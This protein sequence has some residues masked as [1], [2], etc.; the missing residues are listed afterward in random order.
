MLERGVQSMSECTASDSSEHEPAHD[1]AEYGVVIV[2]MRSRLER[3]VAD[4]GNRI[5]QDRSGWHAGDTHE[6]YNCEVL[7]LRPLFAMANTPRLS[8]LRCG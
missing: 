4:P 7:V 8:C 5:K 3:D 6:T 1:F 2:Q